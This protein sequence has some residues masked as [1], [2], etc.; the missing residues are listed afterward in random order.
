M[1]GLRWRL[2]VP[3]VLALAHACSLSQARTSP[4]RF[5]RSD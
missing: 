1:E 4:M 5:S 2:T 3:H